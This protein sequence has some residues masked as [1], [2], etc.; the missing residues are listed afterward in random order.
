MR[1]EPHEALGPYAPAAAHPPTPNQRVFLGLEAP[2]PT[3]G[4]VEV[5]EPVP[6]AEMDT[7][8]LAQDLKARAGH[9]GPDRAWDL[10]VIA[11]GLRPEASKKEF[12]AVWGAVEPARQ[13]ARRL[14]PF[15]PQWYDALRGTLL[16]TSR[17]A[18]GVVRLLWADGSWGTSPAVHRGEYLIE[19]LHMIPREGGSRYGLGTF[20]DGFAPVDLWGAKSFRLLRSARRAADLTRRLNESDAMRWSSKGFAWPVTPAR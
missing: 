7:R 2:W 11:R 13:E 17:G 5:V 15:A 14:L 20:A 3:I 16:E 8:G 6:P 18:E 4:R 10:F 12:T 19:H 1:I 9:L